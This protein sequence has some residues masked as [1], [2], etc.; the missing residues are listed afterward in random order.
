[1][2]LDEARSGDNQG[3]HKVIQ[4]SA[5]AHSSRNHPAHH[6]RDSNSSL[7][8]DDVKSHQTTA[9]ALNMLHKAAK[10]LEI[11]A[12]TS[13][14]AAIKGL[15]MSRALD[16]AVQSLKLLK[17]FV[18]EVTLVTVSIPGHARSKKLCIIMIW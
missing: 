4:H 3:D 9:L 2:C 16:M 10:Q 8:L 1:M 5:Q 11:L 13:F 15:F 14:R 18:T 6:V 12:T 7:L 17:G